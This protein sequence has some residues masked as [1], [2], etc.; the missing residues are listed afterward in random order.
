MGDTVLRGLALMP[1]D[2]TLP[3]GNA[4]VLTLRCWVK[5]NGKQSNSKFDNEKEAR[6]KLQLQIFILRWL[7]C[8]WCRKP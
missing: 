8:S 2:L 5:P 7:V 4:E 6:G 1:L 3:E